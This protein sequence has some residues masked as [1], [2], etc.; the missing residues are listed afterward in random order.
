MGFLAPLLLGLAAALAVPL[1]IHL[2]HRHQGPRVEFPAL[3]YLRRA[4]REHAL[5]IR[6]RQVAVLALRLWILA[7]IVA[8]AARPFLRSGSGQHDPTAA[9]IVL[10]NSLSTGRV[11]G[12]SRILD[13]L[14]S[15]ALEA[16]SAATSDDRF[17]VLPAAGG[18]AASTGSGAE[19]AE[20]VHA[21]EVA[22]A[23]A[24]LNDAVSRAR[25]ILATGS[26]GRAAEVHLLTDLQATSFHGPIAP[27]E[28]PLLVFASM[29]GA[30]N[31][32]V[33]DVQLGGGVPPRSGRRSTV[34][35]R[36]AGPPGDTVEARLVVDD[37]VRAAAL[38]PSGAVTVL[39]FPPH[40]PGPVTGRVEIDPDA[41]RGDDRRFFAVEVRQPPRV[42]VTAEAPFVEDAVSVLA[43]AGRV[44]PA[45]VAQ[46]DVVVAPE[47]VA[48]D[49]APADAT[50]LVLPPVT[51]LRLPALNQRLAAA[52]IP[53]RYGA[54]EAVGEGRLVLAAEDVELARL[55]E[56]VRIRRAYR[57][58]RL[59]TADDTALLKLRDGEPWAVRGRRGNDGPYLLLASSLSDDATTVPVSTAMLPL[60]DRLLGA[61]AEVAAPPR[62]V[63]PS[64][65]VSLPG[66]A[67]SVV[68]PDGRRA[69][70]E[71]G[72]TFT[73]PPVAGV[74][75]VW[76]ADTLLSAFAVNPPA[77][78]SV[79]G[80]A[81]PA[82][83][84]PG[85]DIV[86]RPDAWTDAIF[87]RR[88][89]AELG[90]WLLAAVLAFMV[91]E[92]LVAASG[93]GVEEGRRLPANPRDGTS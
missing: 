42:A 67:R 33:T 20:R 7:L 66:R 80:A 75:T 13:R 10:D 50:V 23:A 28:E 83:V 27:G 84:L 77:R 58:E 78:E 85:A 41:L 65:A 71:G 64:Q 91:M 51:P 36:I 25:A 29:A 21:T 48:L 8:A 55:L 18:S 15:R 47:G 61:W 39:P 56:G 37:Q 9:V 12:E 70:V 76:T 89:G 38:A 35:L 87:H 17:W 11:D 82:A 69:A 90:G 62:S 63:E 22:D 45:A 72:A 43:E 24:D 44:R 5:Q 86:T 57:L 32:A 2:F 4:E 31:R 3:R 30:T 52:G 40:A 34:A 53:L 49:E 16:L 19:L 88:H 60:L 79:L 74:Y 73:A 6:L 59:T 54:A 1:V 81:E 14:A 46:A 68:H 93:R 26:G 92:A